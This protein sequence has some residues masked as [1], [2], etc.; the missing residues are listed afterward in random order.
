MRHP[1]YKYVSTVEGGVNQLRTVVLIDD[2]K[3]PSNPNECF[4]SWCRYDQDYYDNWQGNGNSVAGF[5]GPIYADYLPIDIDNQDI[6][7]A[8]Q[9]CRDF[10]GH[11]RYTLDVPINY[12]RAFFSGSKGFSVEIPIAFFGD[13]YPSEQLPDTFKEIVKSFGF[14]DFDLKIYHHNPLWRRPNTI[15]EKSGLYK[16]PLSTSDIMNLDIQEIKNMASKPVSLNGMYD[17]D[18]CFPVDSLVEL[19]NENVQTS[20]PV[21]VKKQSDIDLNYKGVQEGQRNNTAFKIV[22]DLRAKGYKIN[23]V[24]GYIRDVWNPLNEPPEPDVRSLLRTV[25]SAYRYTI[26]DHQPHKLIQ[27]FRYDPYY[28][29]WDNDQKAIYVDIISRMNEYEKLVWQK[30]KCGPNQLIYSYRT[31]AERNNVSEKKVRTFIKHLEQ[32]GRITNEILKNKG[33]I[34]CSRLTFIGF[35]WTN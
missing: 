15:N 28:N 10:L 22:L 11:L 13:I 20:S 4:T 19:W 1:D 17:F 27:H 33:R 16:I 31:L 32:L 14:G 5:N 3:E 12:L 24:K 25:E 8:Q 9:T 34:D 29:S 6:E 21:S 18:E 35:D 30:Y 23:E 2:I 26:T 7:Q